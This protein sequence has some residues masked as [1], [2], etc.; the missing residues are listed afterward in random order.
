M[1]TE[2]IIA[3]GWISTSFVTGVLGIV[4]GPWIRYRIFRSHARSLEQREMIDYWLSL[5]RRKCSF[6]MAAVASIRQGK[7]PKSAAADAIGA[8]VQYL[9]DEG[10]AG[11][12]PWPF[13]PER[14]VNRRLRKLVEEL[15][16]ETNAAIKATTDLA[17]TGRLDGF[18]ES[19]TSSV[20][21][22]ERLRRDI[23]VAMKEVGL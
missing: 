12:L 3:I 22:C 6:P 1:S 9:K 2:V 5:M 13:D 7:D 14:V 20:N 19:V 4:L 16:E 23:L 18:E 10:R 15:G 21:R 8:F 11:D 17:K